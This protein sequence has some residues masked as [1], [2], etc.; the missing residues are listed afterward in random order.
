VL[1]PLFHHVQEQPQNACCCFKAEIFFNLRPPRSLK[2]HHEEYS[3]LIRCTILFWNLMACSYVMPTTF[4]EVNFSTQQTSGNNGARRRHLLQLD[5]DVSPLVKQARSGVSTKLGIELS[6]QKI[7]QIKFKYWTKLRSA[8]KTY[9]QDLY[10][11]YC[12]DFFLS[13]GHFRRPSSVEKSP[14]GAL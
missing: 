13:R 3:L 2:Q 7:R 4:Q 11:E 5:S 8:R 12:A 1:V 14:N 6:G 10:S 9:G